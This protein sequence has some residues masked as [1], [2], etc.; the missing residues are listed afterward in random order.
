[1]KELLIRMNTEEMDNLK[2]IVKFALERCTSEV[3]LGCNDCP[4]ND[5]MSNCS[6]RLMQDVLK[7]L[8]N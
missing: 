8:E 5:G 7:I 1:M 4:Y 2:I 3:E 6:R